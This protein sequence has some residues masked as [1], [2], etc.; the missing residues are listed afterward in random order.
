MTRQE[1]NGLAE[2][3][4][5]SAILRFGHLLAQ[6]REGSIRIFLYSIAD[7]YTATN[8]LP[9]DELKEIYVYD[10]INQ[11]PPAFYRQLLSVHPAERIYKT[12]EI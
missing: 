3:E 9:D 7:F 12:P 11:L 10:D 2:M 5:L 6:H 8:Y 1:F 4:K